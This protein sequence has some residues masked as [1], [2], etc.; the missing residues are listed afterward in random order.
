MHFKKLFSVE[1][2]SIVSNVD[3]VAEPPPGWF[4]SDEEERG[5]GERECGTS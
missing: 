5:G 2:N 4:I 3:N 1:I